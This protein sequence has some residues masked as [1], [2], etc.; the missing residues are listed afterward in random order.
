MKKTPDLLSSE[1]VDIYFDRKSFSALSKRQIWCRNSGAIAHALDVN[2]RVWW[3][4]NEDQGWYLLDDP[5]ETILRSDFAAFLRRVPR[6][7]RTLSLFSRPGTQGEREGAFQA[8]LRIASNLHYKDWDKDRDKDPSL[9]RQQAAPQ[10]AATEDAPPWSRPWGF[11][12]RL[13]YESMYVTYCPVTGVPARDEG[14]QTLLAA[15][16]ERHTID[17]CRGLRPPSAPLLSPTAS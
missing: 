1:I 5:A 4:C 3:W 6:F 2:N 9:F 7:I 11:E 15:H 13:F 17:H 12:A 14:I 8:L 16:G 10:T